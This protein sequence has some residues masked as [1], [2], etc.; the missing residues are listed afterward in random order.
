MIEC[1]TQLEASGYEITLRGEKLHFRYVGTGEPPE[2]AGRLLEDLSQSK[3]EVI[4]YLRSLHA[5]QAKLQRPVLIES[6]I[7]KDTFHLAWEEEQVKEIE[8]AGSDCYLPGEIRTLLSNSAGMDEGALRDY[9]N[10]VHSVKKAF[11]GAVIKSE[12]S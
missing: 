10:K 3:A 4:N 9:L 1:L 6:D 8:Q 11:P 2:E 12:G 7:L 5:P